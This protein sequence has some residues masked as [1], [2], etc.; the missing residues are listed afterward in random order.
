MHIFPNMC[1]VF[2]DELQ[3]DFE[4]PHKIFYSYIERY[5]LDTLLYFEELLDFHLRAQKC[6]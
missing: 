2:C 6:F 3:R 5:D 4:I 1:K